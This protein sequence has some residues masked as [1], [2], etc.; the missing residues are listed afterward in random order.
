MSPKSIF[1]ISFA[2]ALLTQAQFYCKRSLA[3]EK[4]VAPKDA[5]TVLNRAARGPSWRW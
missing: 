3:A 5:L 2:L 1:L 4:L